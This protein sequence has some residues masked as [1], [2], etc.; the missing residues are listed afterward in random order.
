MSLKS[1]ISHLSI[2]QKENNCEC[3]LTKSYVVIV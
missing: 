2:F 1:R 3:K